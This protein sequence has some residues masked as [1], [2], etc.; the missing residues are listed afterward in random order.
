MQ[1]VGV[2]RIRRPQ[3]LEEGVWVTSGTSFE[4]PASSYLKGAINLLSI[5]CRG[6]T[7]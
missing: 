7:K 4:V 2:H 6:I 3:G 5:A 1:F